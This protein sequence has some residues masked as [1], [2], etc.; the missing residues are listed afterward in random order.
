MY[1]RA[2]IRK[3]SNVYADIHREIKNFKNGCPVAQL[4]ATRILHFVTEA[5]WAVSSKG[6]KDDS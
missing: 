5:A 1:T 6:K 4:S 3:F 2:Q